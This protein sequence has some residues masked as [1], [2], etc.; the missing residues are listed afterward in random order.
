[1]VGFF[2]IWLYKQINREKQRGQQYCVQLEKKIMPS[3]L[4][5]VIIRIHL[6][7]QSL[8]SFED[9]KPLSPSFLCKRQNCRCLSIV[10]LL[11][12]MLYL[13]YYPPKSSPLP[14]RSQLNS[15]SPMRSY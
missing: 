14:G 13:V 15:D 10:A 8:N 6:S 4:K 2:D 7:K 1:M 5:R 3:E 12:F 11:L 9:G